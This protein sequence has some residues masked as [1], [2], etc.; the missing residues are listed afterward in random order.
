MPTS[1]SLDLIHLF[2]LL[3]SRWRF[4]VGGT[5]II[6]VVAGIGTYLAEETYESSAKLL[7]SSPKFAGGLDVFPRTFSEPTF[8][9]MAQ[10]GVVLEDLIQVMQAL[11]SSLP[12]QADDREAALQAANRILQSGSEELAARFG[13]RPAESK[14][15]AVQSL[16]PRDI[17]GLRL[18]DPGQFEVM[19][20]R[21]LS[22]ILDVKAE[23][24]FEGP[25]VIRWEPLIE[26]KA[27]ANAPETAA[28]IANIWAHITLAHVRAVVQLG[29]VD[30]LQQLTQAFADAQHDLAAVQQRIQQLNVEAMGEIKKEHL[31]GILETLYGYTTAETA[32][33]KRDPL[34]RQLS[35]AQARVRELERSIGDLQRNLTSLE[36]DGQWIGSLSL[37]K[38]EPGITSAPLPG[39]ST[40][41]YETRLRRDALLRAYHDLRK[42]KEENPIAAEETRLAEAIKTLD[43]V[44]SERNTFAA[45]L[46][47]SGSTPG[48]TQELQRLDSRINEL[49]K[50]IAETNDRMAAMELG[51]QEKELEVTRAEEEWTAYREEYVRLRKELFARQEE[52][53]SKRALAESIE[54]QIREASVEISKLNEQ[55]E[56]Y[57]ASLSGLDA[58]LQ[59]RK[60]GYEEVSNLHAQ[61][62]VASQTPFVSLKLVSAAPVPKTRVSPNRRL[63]VLVAGFIGFVLL[64]AWVMLRENLR[65][66][67]QAE[68]PA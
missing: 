12:D 52:I 9:Q 28:S 40:A 55:I 22:E 29:T 63:I 37:A 5:L 46:K 26:L 59:A 1:Q 49:E 14:I 56:E 32:E 4:L 35:D 50:L 57:T 51:L 8:G 27:R 39:E 30:A 62:Q 7:V 36:K 67:R 6:M 31:K 2:N 17:A 15:E 18:M 65:R 21:T 33:V 23:I 24:E 43:D 60:K 53:L 38:K 44:R 48:G 68:V 11:H 10:S 34:Y 13:W 20:T 41:A 45:M 61:V 42:F 19:D 3:V 16:A 58:E 64:S 25:N 47:V 54:A 66:Y